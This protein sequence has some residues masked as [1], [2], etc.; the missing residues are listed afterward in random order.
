MPGRADQRHRRHQGADLGLQRRHQ[1]AVDAQ[2]QRHDQ[3]RAVRRCAWTSTATPPPTAPPSSSGPATAPP[4]SAGSRSADPVR[5]PESPLDERAPDALRSSGS[6]LSMHRPPHSTAHSQERT[7]LVVQ[8]VVGCWA[9]ARVLGRSWANHWFP[10]PTARSTASEKEQGVRAAVSTVGGSL[11]AVAV[12]VAAALAAGVTGQVPASAAT[13]ATYYVAPNGNDANPGTITSPFRTLQRA[14]DVVRTVNANMTGDIYVYLR[15]GSY[16][17]SSTDRVRA[18]RLRH[19][20]LPGHLRR[21]PERDAG[22]RRRRSGDRM[23]PAQRQHLEGP[24]RPRQQAACALRQR[25]AGVHGVED[26]QLGGMLRDVQHHGR[27]GRVGVGVGI[28]VRRRQVQPGRLSRHRPQPGRHRDRDGRRPG[29][30]PSWGS[31]R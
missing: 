24:A 21:V 28:A 15:G 6:Q 25:Q 1:P 19:Q 18:G 20:R 26:D 27:A 29:P 8:P 7:E 22:P 31:A 5:K 16:P 4:T 10:A 12:L 13:Q 11:L 9:A 30:R 17:V 14:R 2:R 3:Q 23:D